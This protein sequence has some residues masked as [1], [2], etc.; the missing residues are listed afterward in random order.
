LKVPT[1][2]RDDPSVGARIFLPGQV[3]E[4][5]SAL[6][7]TEAPEQPIPI[8][9]LSDLQLPSPTPS[10]D[11]SGSTITVIPA[12]ERLSNPDVFPAPHRPVG[13][14]SRL[15]MVGGLV[16]LI[17]AIALTAGATAN[18]TLTF[19]LDHSAGADQPIRAIRTCE[20]ETRRSGSSASEIS[21]GHRMPSSA[22]EVVI[23]PADAAA[24][25][26]F[27]FLIKAAKLSTTNSR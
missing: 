27:G 7:A 21:E 5:A 9:R 16:G 3:S 6:A 26:G 1:G 12:E 14:R 10:K 15:A 17:L 19:H 20:P 24:V 13:S 23:P 18:L 22:R 8:F 11:S 4:A 25:L 2:R